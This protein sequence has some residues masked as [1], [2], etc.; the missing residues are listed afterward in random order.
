[1]LKTHL[2]IWNTHLVEGDPFSILKKT[3]G[4][5]DAVQP[6]HIQNTIVGGHVLW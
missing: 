5:P 3:I 4:S 2:L 6:T 1:M